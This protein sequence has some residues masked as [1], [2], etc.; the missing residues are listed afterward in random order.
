MKGFG[1][2]AFFVVLEAAFL[3]QSALPA[4]VHARAPAPAAEAVAGKRREA[5]P[6]RRA[7]PAAT[8]IPAIVPPDGFRAA[9]CRPT[10]R[11]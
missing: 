6:L 11:C 8:V 2:L 10:S 1:L 9:S 4:G 3:L 5:Y 7:A